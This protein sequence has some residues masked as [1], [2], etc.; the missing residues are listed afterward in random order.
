M[1]RAYVV[2]LN[3]N[4]WATTLQCLDAL[5]RIDGDPRVVVVDNGSDDP[6]GDSILS[7]RDV[8]FLQTGRNLG[9][10]GGNNVGIR[11]ALDQGAEYIWILNNDVLP[12][13]DSLS[14]LVAAADADPSWGALSSRIVTA[15]GY[16][17]VGL[18]IPEPADRWDPFDRVRY[19]PVCAT[20]EPE[21]EVRAVAFL[22]GPSLLVR[23]SALNETGLFDERYFHYFEEMDL[24]ERLRRSGWRLGV[25]CTSVVMHE[26][27]ATLSYDTPQ[28]HHYLIRNQLLFE[29]KLFGATPL[30]VILRHPIR[31]LR[32][33]LALRHLLRGDFR[34][35]IAHARAMSDAMRGR[36]GHV[37]LGTAFRQPL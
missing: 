3:W 14:V 4:R 24:M 11:H 30:R 22:R 21:E 17:D 12:S 7:G 27:G 37:D 28:A 8:D 9:Y 18:I 6:D 26:K 34:L 15:D 10:A 36:F 25:A 32:A 29:D 31:R 33:L 5:V 1:S 35:S 16:E 13:P 19:G 2:V 20:D 23:S